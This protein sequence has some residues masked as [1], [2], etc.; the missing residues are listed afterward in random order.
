MKRKNK[1]E[2]F[3]KPNNIKFDDITSFSIIS[4]LNNI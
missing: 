1:K 4:H 3:I 2:T